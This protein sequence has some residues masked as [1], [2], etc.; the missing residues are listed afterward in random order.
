MVQFRVLYPL[1]DTK[2]LLQYWGDFQASGPARRDGTISAGARCTCGDGGRCGCAQGKL[3]CAKRYKKDP[4]GGWD[5]VDVDET[6]L[7]EAERSARHN[8]HVRL[9]KP[10]FQ[11]CLM[12]EKAAELGR[13]FNAVENLPVRKVEI[14][15]AC[16]M[17][18]GWEDM[19]PNLYLVEPFLD[20]NSPF[21]KFN[22]NDFVPGA[23][24]VQNTPNM[25]SLFS[26]FHSNKE[27]LVCDIQG[28]KY[29]FTDPQFHTSE[30]QSIDDDDYDEGELRDWLHSG[31]APLPAPV[32]PLPFSPQGF[33]SAQAD[34]ARR[35]DGGLEMMKRVLLGLHSQQSLH[36]LCAR[37]W[38]EQMAEFNRQVEEWK[39]DPEFKK[40]MEEWEK[41]TNAYQK[42]FANLN[43]VLD[44]GVGT[45]NDMD[46]ELAAAMLKTKE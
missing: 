31:S 42:Y 13:A 35:A 11:D 1:L 41:E 5:T 43:P 19:R 44:A 40:Q 12:Q 29:R 33:R 26:Y 22:N 8:K 15:R 32:Q 37:I 36:A 38:P 3:F 24:A 18:T 27:L 14:L 39:E 25:Y 7:S 9:L 45:Y 21:R 34:G 6:T 10:L 20:D 2:G 46:A 30:K 28:K 16:V 17:E 23:Q 4:Q